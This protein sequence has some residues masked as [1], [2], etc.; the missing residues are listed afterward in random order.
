MK[1]PGCASNPTGGRIRQWLGI[2]P[3]R[4]RTVHR[5]HQTMRRASVG[6]QPTRTSRAIWCQSTSSA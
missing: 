2:T 6:G 3:A 4:R 5:R 1:V